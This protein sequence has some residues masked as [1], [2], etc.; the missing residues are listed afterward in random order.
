[1][2]KYNEKALVNYY[3]KL[4]WNKVYKEKDIPEEIHDKVMN[5]VAEYQK[6]KSDND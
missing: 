4:V 3:A 1:M 6:V 5:K 2:N